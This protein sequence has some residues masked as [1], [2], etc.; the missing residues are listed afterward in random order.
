MRHGL[1]PA[2]VAGIVMTT[3]PVLA[4]NQAAVEKGAYIFTDQKCSLCH[5]VAGKGNAKGP[6]EDGVA[7]LS[8]DDIRQW[9]VKPD[10]MRVKAGAE[11]KP[12]MKS[13]AALSK[14][15]LDALVAYLL[16]LKKK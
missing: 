8:S 16:S 12:I 3:A 15:D 9:L 2:A 1:L 6:L 14:G 4:Q 5:S 10:A 7:N 13:F 11:R